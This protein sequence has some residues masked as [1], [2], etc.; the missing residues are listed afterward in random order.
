MD[1]SK[2]KGVT[3]NPDRYRNYLIDSVPHEPGKCS[4]CGLF[5]PCYQD[6]FDDRLECISCYYNSAL[7]DV[8]GQEAI[9]GVSGILVEYER[10]HIGFLCHEHMHLADD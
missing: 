5:G 3:N 9:P 4:V 8:C 6:P 2:P 1:E 10:Y 7:C